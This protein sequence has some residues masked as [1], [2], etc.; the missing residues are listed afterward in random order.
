[1]KQLLSLL[2]LTAVLFIF[3]PQSI[4]AYTTNMNASLVIGQADFTHGSANQGGK[5]DR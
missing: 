1:M 2:V 3:Q 4:Y 5:R